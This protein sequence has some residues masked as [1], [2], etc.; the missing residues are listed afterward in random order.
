M[1]LFAQVVEYS[2]FDKTSLAMA[3]VL[4]LEKTSISSDCATM[5]VT[6]ITGDYNVTTNPTG[7]GAPN[8]T[9]ANLYLKLLVHLRK[10]TGRE[11]IAVPAYNENT[12]SSWSIDVSNSEDGWLELYLFGCK[13]WGSGVTYQ[14]NYVAYDASTDKYYRSLQN[15]NTNHLVSDTAWWSEATDIDHFTA[16]R[17]A[18]QPDTYSVTENVVELCRS[19][20]CEAQML[21]KAGC[22]CC[23]ECALKEY[24]K[25]RMKIEAAAIH[26]ALENFTEAQIIVENLNTVCENLVDCGCK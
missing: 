5:V 6:E 17:T 11:V 2:I 14:L 16:A 25:V 7:F 12:A 21:I 8:E 1:G 22:N 19:R 15:S 23:D 10:S 4:K 26:E 20:K 18:S 9:R 13:A 24:E 3:L